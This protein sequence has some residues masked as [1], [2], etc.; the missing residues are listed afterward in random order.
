MQ[1]PLITAVIPTYGRRPDLLLNAVE[2]IANQTYKNIEIII[3]D[4]SS[5]QVSERVKSRTSDEIEIRCLCDGDHNGPAAARNVGIRASHGEFIAFLDDDDRWLPEKTIRQLQM[6]SED[7]GLVCV[8]QYYENESGQVVNDR[9]PTICGDVTESLLRGRH[10][11]PTSS[12]MIRAELVDEYDLFFDERLAYWED[13][14]WYLRVSQYCAVETISDPLTVRGIGDYDR[15][16]DDFEAI[17]DKYRPLYNRKH[18]ALAISYSKDCEREFVANLSQSI[19]SAALNEG[20]Y[21]DARRYA[22]HAIKTYP[23]LRFPYVCLL[24]SLGGRFT[25]KSALTFRQR[26]RSFLSK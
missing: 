26:A 12:A 15:L 10:L 24:V 6:F 7:V 3:V 23:S 1:E 5:E 19:A 21:H 2:S 4:D 25:H 17:R 16:S 13:K 18:R 11:A 14:D 22:F 20:Q 9:R 8:G